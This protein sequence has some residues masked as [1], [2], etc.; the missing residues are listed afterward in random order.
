MLGVADAGQLQQMRR[1]DRAAGEDDLSR[2]FGA[3]DLA[4]A[5]K[6]DTDRALAVET[7]RDGPARR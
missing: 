7:A 4:A 2:R 1:A 6:L 3:L 5:R